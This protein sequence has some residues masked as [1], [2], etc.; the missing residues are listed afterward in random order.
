MK[1]LLAPDDT[2]AEVLLVGGALALALSAVKD[3]SLGD[4]PKRF[5]NTLRSK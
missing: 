5:A 2:R 4:Q 1:E 3:A